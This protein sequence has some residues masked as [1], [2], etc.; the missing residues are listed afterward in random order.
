MGNVRKVY[1][2]VNLD[3]DESGNIR[4]RRITWEDG[5][6][7]EID[8]LRHRCRAASTRVGGCGIRYTVVIG[9][10]ETYLFQEDDRWFVE[11]KGGAEPADTREG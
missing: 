7:Y 2:K 3:V 9:G 8:R 4:P 1:V 6:V 11:G 5:R 10:K